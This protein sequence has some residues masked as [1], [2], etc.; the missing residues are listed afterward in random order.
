MYVS[1]R[2]RSYVNQNSYITSSRY[3]EGLDVDGSCEGVYWL[4]SLRRE[5]IID[6][7]RL[8]RA[9]LCVERENEKD[10]L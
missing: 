4:I 10:C 5:M 1:V 7:L 6:I 3:N 2:T 8:N 9:F